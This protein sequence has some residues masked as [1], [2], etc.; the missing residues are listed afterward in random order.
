MYVGTLIASALA[1]IGGACLLYRGLRGK[2]VGDH[3]FC[4][5]CMYDLFGIE[6]ALCP[7][8][9]AD[10]ANADAKVTGERH[11]LKR[12]L[13]AGL[14][15][16]ALASFGLGVTIK[17]YV[18]TTDW[19]PIKPVRL[20]KHEAQSALTH[21]EAMKELQR[22]LDAQVLSEGQIDA[23]AAAALA[24]QADLSTT[25]DADW[26]DF[27]EAART[28][29]KLSD[30]RWKQYV[31]QALEQAVSTKSVAVRQNVR[32]HDPL[33]IAVRYAPARLGWK[34]T[35]RIE[36]E[37]TVWVGG[38]LVAADPDTLKWSE[39]LSPF[40]GR[41]AHVRKATLDPLKAMAAAQGPQLAWI[42]VKV[43]VP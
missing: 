23:T 39:V 11:R 21:T 9:G 34:G 25:W 32:P 2:R 30:E 16:V 35:R 6:T 3:L 15:I 41:E 7:E 20:L 27:V 12:P 14:I 17:E 38:E 10:L 1:L 22:R 8:C 42:A 13:I 18:A 4:R 29:G 33:P 24:A 31:N 5:R 19:Q 43:T 40:G 26:G 36:T 28:A 37:V